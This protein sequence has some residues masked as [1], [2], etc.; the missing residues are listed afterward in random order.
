VTPLQNAETSNRLPG[1]APGGEGGG[2]YFDQSAYAVRFEWGANG[3]DAVGPGS[4]VIVIVDALSFTTCVEI[5]VSR[6]AFILPWHRHDESAE[7]YAAA[8][9]ALRAGKR[10]GAGV[11]YS[12]S[13]ASLRAI[14]AGTRLVLPSPNG[15]TLS[16][17]AAA[18]GTT[19]AACLR[20]GAAVAEWVRQMGGTVAV[21]ACGERWPDGSLRPAVED[22]LAAGAVIA[23]L[24]GR[25][26]PEAQTAAEAFLRLRGELPLVL[27]ECS[28]G[29]ELLER[30]F[31][32]DVELAAELNVSGTVPVLREG[33]YGPAPD[34]GNS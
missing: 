9:Q 23:E 21:V 22:L 16:L 4:D 15:G 7:Q 24:P 2:L 31:P 33:V 32:L 34:Q 5:A 11:G 13:P 1:A 8:Q 19:A 18:H 10:G 26:S 3:L 20:N 14:P 25:H 30:G 6:G 28:S 17:Q 29:R 27:R 12:L